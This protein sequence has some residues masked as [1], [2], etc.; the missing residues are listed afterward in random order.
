MRQRLNLYIEGSWAGY[1]R[2]LGDA[3]QCFSPS[4][5]CVSKM[6][7][8]IKVSGHGSRTARHSLADSACRT[9]Q[10]WSVYW[11]PHRLQYV[12]YVT[13]S[14]FIGQVRI[15]VKHHLILAHFTTCAADLGPVEPLQLATYSWTWWKF[16]SER[17]R[18]REVMCNEEAR[19]KKV[20]RNR[21]E[22][23]LNT[24]I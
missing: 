22:A 12:L 21:T 10:V 4:A 13:N 15:A 9:R 18:R 14:G 20:N 24:D 16:F 5:F 1:Y 3:L 17:V 8:L 6:E 23:P 2:G 11:W 19:W 7:I